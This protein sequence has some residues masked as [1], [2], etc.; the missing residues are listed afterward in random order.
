M[1]GCVDVEKKKMRRDA[2][3]DMLLG[4]YLEV[5]VPLGYATCF[6]LIYVGPN[7]A[8]VGHVKADYWQ[9]APVDELAPALLNMTLLVALDAI[10]LVIT[11][12]VC[13]CRCKVSLWKLFLLIQRDFG[14]L[15]L[16]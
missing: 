11:A 4:E 5:I 2:V 14:F 10:S 15:F 9:Y 13:K 8:L 7:A 16:G 3:L 1:G 12:F 6:I